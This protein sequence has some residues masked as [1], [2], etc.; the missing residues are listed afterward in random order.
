MLPDFV[1]VIVVAAVIAISL[2]SPS[3]VRLT[4]LLTQ[5]NFTSVTF[6][7]TVAVTVNAGPA[8]PVIVAVAAIVLFSYLLSVRRVVIAVPSVYAVNAIR[9]FLWPLSSNV[10]IPAAVVVVTGVA[11]APTG[12]TWEITKFVPST[13]V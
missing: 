7:K 1:A 2:T 11:N 12:T 5:S 9:K 8:T 10:Q 4:T 13:D 6:V 3:T